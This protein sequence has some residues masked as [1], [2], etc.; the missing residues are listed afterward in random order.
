M[1]SVARPGDCER[2]AG[3]AR[4]IESGPRCEPRIP[5]VVVGRIAAAARRRL[6]VA[7]LPRIRLAEHDTA[8]GRHW[9][10]IGSGPCATAGRRR[11]RP[12]GRCLPPHRRGGLSAPASDIR[13]QDYRLA[14]GCRSRWQGARAGGWPGRHR[15]PG[16][17]S[18]LRIGRRGQNRE[19][20]TDCSDSSTRRGQK[21]AGHARQLS[22]PCRSSVRRLVDAA[23]PP[24]GRAPGGRR[25]V[26]WSLPACRGDRARGD[27]EGLAGP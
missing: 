10:I 7:I 22:T 1:A 26:G 15:G 23:V 14:G 16:G 21:G 9:T 6:T 2:C 25:A 27:G 11:S 5:L 24:A 12:Y 8:A 13:A 4:R 18:L 20:P 3:G 17:R 19:R